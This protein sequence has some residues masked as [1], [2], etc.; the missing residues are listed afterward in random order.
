M[1]SREVF[2]IEIRHEGLN[3]TRQ[4]RGT[5]KAE[6]DAKARA[7][8]AAWDRIWQQRQNMLRSPPETNKKEFAEQ[9][10][11][12]LRLIWDQTSSILRSAVDKPHS[13][14]WETLK[15][16]SDFPIPAPSKPQKPDIPHEP[17]IHDECFQPKLGILDRLFSNRRLKKIEQASQLFK[18]EHRKWD[19]KRKELLSQYEASQKQYEIDLR[20][21]TE[22]KRIF[23]QRQQARNQLLDRRRD[24]YL[25]K[26]TD[27][28]IEYC[29]LVLGAS[30]YPK[31]F[32]RRAEL[33]YEAETKKLTVEYQLPSPEDLPKIK[34]LQYDQLRDEI[35]EIIIPE[36][37]LTK[38]YERL[39]YQICLRVLYELYEADVIGTLDSII[40]NGWID[41]TENEKQDQKRQQVTIVSLQAG[42]R[43]FFSLNL[44]EIESKICLQQLKAS[45]NLE[46]LLA[47]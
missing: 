18:Y 8:Y 23:Q 37:T 24:A 32:P 35:R 41:S 5:D 16:H 44:R 36:E 4:I 29:R 22:E 25:K 27:G 10:N 39:I 9:R 3:R 33:A 46:S 6:V 30:K 47:I 20:R 2:E 28:I 38:Y 14:L 43:E 26:T 34:E 45:I 15:D 40:L 1:T 42:R 21:W 17:T 13:V 11:R 12:E 31:G 7:Q 19:V